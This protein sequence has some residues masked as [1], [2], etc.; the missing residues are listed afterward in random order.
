MRAYVQG[1]TYTA[2]APFSTEQFTEAFEW[3]QEW[4]NNQSATHA[5][6]FDQYGLIWDNR[7][8]MNLKNR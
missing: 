5:E 2:S 1:K 7:N 6:I 3:C 8:G 4:L